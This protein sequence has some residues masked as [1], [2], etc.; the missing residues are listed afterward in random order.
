LIAENEPAPLDDDLAA[1]LHRGRR[2]A[3]AMRTLKP[4]ERDAVLDAKLEPLA[5]YLNRGNVE[6]ICANGPGEIGIA[7]A[8]NGTKWIKEPRL[9]AKYWD[10]LC[11]I[12]ANKSGVQFDV[13]RQPIV[14]TRLP[15]GHR[16]EAMLGKSVSETGISVSIRVKREFQAD[17]LAFG[18]A[19]GVAETSIGGLS[20]QPQ[21]A[22][23][24]A[25]NLV[26][27]LSA[28]VRDG[29][30]IL[31]S[32]GTSSG[33][34]TLLNALARFIPEDK[35]VLC[36]EDT[37][38]IDLPHVRNRNFFVVSR[39]EANPNVGYGEIFDHMMRSHPQI[40]I[41]GELSIRNAYP[42]LLLMNSGHRGFMCT[43][44]ANS[45]RLAVEEGFY[46]RIT[47]GGRA[48]GKQD[49]STYLRG[50]IDIVIQCGLG[51]DGDRRILEIWEPGRERGGSAA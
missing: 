25:V 16:F 2:G 49:L 1:V 27:R 13:E 39:N 46:Q 47:L 9:T 28:A 3:L 20:S 44:H 35:R 11:H 43:M 21:G 15:G 51:W 41:A 12:L 6:E 50:A 40:I 14:S 10:E 17:L 37:R 29:R 7:R 33:K 30:N 34:T 8:D 45:A 32:G 22:P 42:A 24:T 36:V 38:E 31:I 18:I 19:S 26:E 23:G 4:C 48:V 5:P